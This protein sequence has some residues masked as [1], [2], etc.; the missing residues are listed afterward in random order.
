MPM[1]IIG[2]ACLIGLTM[3]GSKTTATVVLVGVAIALMSISSEGSYL[4]ERRQNAL[5]GIE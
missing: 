4:N 3:E 2:T 5:F 1:E